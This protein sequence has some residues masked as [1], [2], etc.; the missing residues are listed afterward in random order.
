MGLPP[1]P[2][3]PLLIF[4]CTIL[5]LEK[6]QNDKILISPK[7]PT[8]CPYLNA[9]FYHLK[10]AK[11]TKYLFRP[12]VPTKCSYS[13]TIWGYTPVLKL[14]LTKIE[15]LAKTYM[16]LEFHVKFLQAFCL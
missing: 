16:E 9:P 1:T 14:D 2:P 11:M 7:V 4:N 5:S 12:K 3:P 8:K 10:K 6:C 15:L 13:E